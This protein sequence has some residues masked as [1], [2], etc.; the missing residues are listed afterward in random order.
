MSVTGQFQG[1]PQRIWERGQ[2]MA[3]PLSTGFHTA[4]AASNKNVIILDLK[5]MN[6]IMEIDFKNQI[7]VI[8]PYVRAIDLQT[9]TVKRGLNCHIVSSGA[10]HSLLAS[11]AAAWGYGV[12]GAATSFSGRNLLGVEWVLPNGEVV[13]IGSAGSGCGWFSPDGPSWASPCPGVTAA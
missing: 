1:K 9:E 3:K 13:T 2:Y 4:A 7:A 8:E 11:H 6:R 5:R 10:N 12:S